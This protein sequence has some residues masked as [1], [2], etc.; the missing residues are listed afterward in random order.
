MAQFATLPLCIF[1][2]ILVVFMCSKMV[3]IHGNP[4]RLRRDGTKG[5]PN[6]GVADGL[7]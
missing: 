5:K 2:S 4:F 6:I 7:T 1:L 3:E